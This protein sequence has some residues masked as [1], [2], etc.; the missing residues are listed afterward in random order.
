MH[1]KARRIEI[2][3]SCLFHVFEEVI[4]DSARGKRLVGR[5]QIFVYR[6]ARGGGFVLCVW[7]GEAGLFGALWSN[8]GWE[9]F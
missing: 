1:E 8:D 2:V 6:S 7:G 9:L 3:W 4:W 5:L